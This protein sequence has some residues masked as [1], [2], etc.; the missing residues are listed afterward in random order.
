M[1]ASIRTTSLL[2]LAA[3][4][5]VL[6]LSGCGD[7][8]G[9]GTSSSA[10]PATSAKQPA[11]IPPTGTTATRAAPPADPPST[12]AAPIEILIKDFKYQGTETA[13]PGAMI[14]VINEDIE[15]HSIT[16]DTGA[17]FDAVIKAGTGTFT[18]PTEP[19]TYAYHCIFHGNM[20]GTL[21]V[22]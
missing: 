16:A 3:A 8:G 7:P 6:V 1:K 21:T 20:H 10:S 13:D 12:G 18:A 11:S 15:A 9:P 4:A 14:T 22:K 19:G 17:A 5:A 2:G